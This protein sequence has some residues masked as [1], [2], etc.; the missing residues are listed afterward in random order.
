MSLDSTLII[1]T[2]PPT[3]REEQFILPPHKEGEYGLETEAAKLIFDL[4]YALRVES[5]TR[6]LFANYLQNESF[7]VALGNGRKIVN[8][9]D[10]V[11]AYN[12]MYSS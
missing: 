10:V 5:E 6:L 12:A 8:A 3:F 7:R 11:I 2:E 4:K 9:N 1:H